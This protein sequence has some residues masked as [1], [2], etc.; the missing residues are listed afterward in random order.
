[1]SIFSKAV[2]S[3]L[4]FSNQY[5]DPAEGSRL[6]NERLTEYLYAEEMGVDGIMLNDTTTPPSACKLAS[7]CLPP[8][9]RPRRSASRSSSWAT[10]C[11]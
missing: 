3:Q 11:R 1:M 7:I 9:S 8:S 4:M 2:R 6:Y 5:F 10:R